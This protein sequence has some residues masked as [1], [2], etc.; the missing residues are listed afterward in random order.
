M[1][2]PPALM[3]IALALWAAVSLAQEGSARAALALGACASAAIGCRPQLAL[4]VLPMLAAALWQAPGWRRRG[5][6]LAVFTLVSLAW[7]LPLVL[8][9]GGLEGFLSY[10][11]RQ[12]SYV[13]AH[14]AARIVSRARVFAIFVGHPWGP[15][16]LS[17]PVLL[18][19]LAGGARLLWLRR[20]TVL[21]LATLS[22]VHLAFCLLVM[23]PADGVRYVLPA[24]LGIAFAA[25]GGYE[26]VASQWRLPAL[27]WIFTGLVLAASAAYAW[28]V[29]RVRSTTPSPA[30]QAVAWVQQNLTHKAM[31]LVEHD[32]EA[33]AAYMLAGYDLAPVDEGLSRATRRPRAPLYLFSEGESGWPGAV[34]FRWPDSDAYRRLTRNHYRVVSLSPIPTGQRFQIVRGIYGWEPTNR[35]AR[36]RWMDAGAS[37]LVFPRGAARGVAVELALDATAPIPANSVAVSVDGAPAATM[38][39]PRGGRR[40]VELPIPSQGSVEITFRSVR[41]FEAPDGRRLAVQLLAVERIPR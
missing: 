41:S 5:E 7:F 25:A 39:V 11:G 2:D 32:M 17:L 38:E 30:A 21:P 20:K 26:I 1:S 37:L 13:A 18:P 10:Q 19:A 4:A 27:T 34:T 36:W 14:D 8:A 33:H 28:P 29:L 31:F 6:A 35:Q 24:V 23:D 9:T 40:T 16:W 22:T 12:A 15:R 3:F